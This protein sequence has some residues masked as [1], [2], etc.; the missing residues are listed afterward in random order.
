MSSP[1]RRYIQDE[2]TLYLGEENIADEEARQIAGEFATSAALINLVLE[3]GDD[4]AVVLAHALVINHWQISHCG[5]G[6]D[7][8]ALVLNSLTD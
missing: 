5:I 3:I 7:G 2:E 8:A 1:V 6:S 4:G